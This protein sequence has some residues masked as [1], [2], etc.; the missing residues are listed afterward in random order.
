MNGFKAFT[1]AIFYVFIMNNA[2]ADLIDLGVDLGVADKYTIGV[3]QWDFHGSPV[4]GSLVLGSEAYIYGNV[5]ASKDIGFASGAIVYG[6]A[7]SNTLIMGSASKVTGTQSICA[8]VQKNGSSQFDQLSIDI[9][10]ASEAAKNLAG[11]T[12][13]A[14]SQSTTLDAS[15]LNVVN[16]DSITLGS[17]D[18]LQINGSSNDNL[19]INILGNAQIAS[20]AQILL[21]D[22]LTSANVLFNFIDDNFSS[23][24]FGGANISGTFLATKGAFNAGDGATL[25]DV[26]FYTNHALVGNFQTVRTASPSIEVP[27]P[28]TILIILA[29]I[30]ILLM[31]SNHKHQ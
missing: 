7:C 8:D 18:I 5:A 2:Q 17:S 20:G 29:G 15:Q 21:S 11:V 28:S 30:F 4:D 31:R 22:G 9:A 19:I 27:E 25:D 13:G 12:Q 26:R 24:N 1:T 14:I 23:L 3:G 6:N 16:V 10:S